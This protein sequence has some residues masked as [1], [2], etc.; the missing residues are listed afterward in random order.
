M[1]VG[2]APG[3]YRGHRRAAARARLL[4]P[5]LPPGGLLCAH[6]S[7]CPAAG[8]A[9][10]VVGQVVAA[11]AGLGPARARESR[12]PRPA[13]PRPRSAGRH[14]SFEQPQMLGRLLDRVQCRRCPIDPC[15]AGMRSQNGIFH[16]A[17]GSWNHRAPLDA[18]QYG[19]VDSHPDGGC[20][21]TGRHRGSL[22]DP[23]SILRFGRFDL[24]PAAAGG[25]EAGRADTE[26]AGRP[27]GRGAGYKMHQS[28]VAKI[29]SGERPVSIG[30][31]VQLAEVLGVDLGELTTERPGDHRTGQ[32]APRT[33]RG[34]DTGPEPAAPGR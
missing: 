8:L 17:W 21:A 3:R 7:R 33:R 19:H 32:S 11:D 12:C 14:A 20:N 15:G 16:A 9:V 24:R 31:A 29:E 4:P 1:Q 18:T 28:T 22:G 27:D 30:E 34:A 2:A 13:V 5:G 26:A 10:D 23:G 6:R 25:P